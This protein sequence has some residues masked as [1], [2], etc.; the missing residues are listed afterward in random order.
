MPGGGNPK[1]SVRVDNETWAAFEQAC[2]AAG[3]PPDEMHYKLIAW[4]ARR[5][6][7]PPRPPRAS[8]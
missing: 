7:L 8:E 3:V 1:R 4:W 2:E 6:T 5:V